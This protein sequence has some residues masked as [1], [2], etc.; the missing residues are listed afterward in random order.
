MGG[1]FPDGATMV[2]FNDC[3]VSVPLL[4]LICRFGAP[5]SRPLGLSKTLKSPF[6]FFLLKI[7]FTYLRV[8]ENGWG[9]GRGPSS[10]LLRRE[11][12]SPQGSRTLRS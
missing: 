4:L 5:L 1:V 3:W 10:P 8:G 11:L 7:V 9:R 2:T 12:P 6:S